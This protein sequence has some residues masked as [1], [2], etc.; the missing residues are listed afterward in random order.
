[1]L[2]CA[3]KHTILRHR[4]QNT[5]Q[6]ALAIVLKCTRTSR[7]REQRYGGVTQWVVIVSI[8]LGCFFRIE[9][10]ALILTFSF[11]Q[12]FV[13][14]NFIN[15]N[16]IGPFLMWIL[17]YVDFKTTEWKIK[18]FILF[19]NRMVISDFIFSYIWFVHNKSHKDMQ[20]F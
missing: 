20:E 12:I 17:R 3:L 7:K 16:L 9:N 8:F 4:C 10:F 2:K 1:M 11:S 13:F 18:W 14:Y 19:C 6:F 15:N 5:P